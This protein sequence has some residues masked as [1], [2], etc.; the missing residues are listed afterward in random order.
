MVPRLIE[1]FGLLRKNGVRL[2][3]AETL[4]AL[5]AVEVV[6]IADPEALR[7]ALVASLVKRTADEEVFD[8]LFD[9]YFFRQGDFAAR[10]AGSG[11]PLI[12]EL[13]SRGFTEEEIEALLAVLADE[14]ARMSPTARM[15][16]GLRR[17]HVEA[18]IRLAGVQVDLGRLVNPLQ[19]GFFTQQ[20]VDRLQFR[21]AESELAALQARLARTLG[22]GRAE[23]LAG[24]LSANLGRLRSAVRRFVAD[25]FERRN[26]EFVQQWRGQMLAEKPFSQMSEEELA[27]LRDEVARLC[28]KLRQMASL[29]RK[30]ERRGRL[31]A[32]RTIRRSLRTGGVPFELKHRR[33]RVD[34][35]RLV[36]LC[37]I[38]DSVRNVSRFML[39]FAYTLQ[40]QFA[41]VRSFVFVSDLGETTDLFREHEIDRAITLA[42]G[43][44]V[45]NVYAN[46]NFGHAFVMFR[47]RFNDAVTTKTT[48]IVIGDGR[49]NYHPPEAWALAD[50][51][52]RA[53]RVL[54]LNPEPPL[55][56]AFGDSAMRDYEPHCDRVEVVNNLSSLKRVVDSLIV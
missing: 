1:F 18:L 53:K 29:R 40:D 3:T 54:W 37:D 12:E 6:G 32:R 50:V 9:L 24:I 26:V 13:R 43:G 33:R 22:P 31:D 48:V 25:E 52:A 56:W 10:A 44:A 15:G 16:L 45:I 5:R 55:S 49:N 27:R 11:A 21:Q 41:Q 17:G 2:S 51:R 34:R 35:P 36:V 47:R 4:D 28:R 7:G 38:S 30:V 20:L 42:Y 39:Q 23:E 46:S 19:I 14:A 8:E